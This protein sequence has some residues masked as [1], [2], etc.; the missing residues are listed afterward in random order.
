MRVYA[1]LY[2]Q[3][4]GDFPARSVLIFV[5]ELDDDAQWT[6]AGMDPA[7]YPGLSIRCTR[8]QDIQTAMLDFHTT[9]ESIEE[10]MHRP[11]DSSGFPN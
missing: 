9:V 6:G 1:E 10:E 4:T 2:R 7:R 8:T 3:Q 11:Y 5:G